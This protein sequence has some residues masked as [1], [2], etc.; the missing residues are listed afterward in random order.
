[1]ARILLSRLRP[2][3]ALLLGLPV[4]ASTVLSI[5]DVDNLRGDDR[6]KRLTIR[7]ACIDAPQ[8]AQSP[9]RQQSRALLA[10]LAPVGSDVS[11]RMV[12][13]KQAFAYRQYL[14]N[15]DPTTYL[16]AERGVE[17]VR[18][19][20]WSVP[21]GIAELVGWRSPR[22]LPARQMLGATRSMASRAW[23]RAKR[24]SGRYSLLRIVA[25]SRPVDAWNLVAMHPGLPVTVATT[26]VVYN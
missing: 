19:G 1:M 16:G 14:T 15:C 8:M 25:C 2:L 5:G 3:L 11:L 18:L 17:V 20:V 22:A 9:Y 7:L 10:G 21:G 24:G 26:R 23:R 13:H 12:R 4:Q 6:G